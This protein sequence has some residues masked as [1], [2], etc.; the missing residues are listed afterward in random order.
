MPQSLDELRR[1]L[2]LNLSFYS[3]NYVSFFILLTLF[4]ILSNTTSFV[5][6]F[7]LFVG[8]LL[9]SQYFK[10]RT[11]PLRI[12]SFELSS[13]HFFV[14][15]ALL[16]LVAFFLLITK[17]LWTLFVSGVMSV[18]HAMLRDPTLSEKALLEENSDEEGGGG[19]E[20]GLAYLKQ[21][22]V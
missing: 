19:E 9:G 8:W 20:E 17:V 14:L 13:S 15:I 1:S 3:G 11:T 7:V 18:T 12:G 22:R 21:G 16:S 10:S 4:S 2:Q 6:V 5:V